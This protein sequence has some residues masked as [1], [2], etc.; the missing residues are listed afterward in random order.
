MG[1]DNMVC[2]AILMESDPGILGK[3]PDYVLEKFHQC[4]N[5][6]NPERLLDSKNLAKLAAYRSIWCNTKL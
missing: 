2:F 6:D 3:S 5:N 4:V 1:L